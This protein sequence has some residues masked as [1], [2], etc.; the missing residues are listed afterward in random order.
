MSVTGTTTLIVSEEEFS[1]SAVHFVEWHTYQTTAEVLPKT[2]RVTY[3]K[4]CTKLL[5]RFSSMK[6]ESRV[7]WVM[8]Y[9]NGKRLVFRTV[10]EFESGFLRYTHED[11]IKHLNTN[12][13]KTEAAK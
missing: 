1:H 10:E 11:L 4:G 12:L 9:G 6:D 8:P 5:P 2:L 7:R 3:G 13:G